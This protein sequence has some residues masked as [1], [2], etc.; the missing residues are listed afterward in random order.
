MFLPVKGKQI[1]TTE[2]KT[3]RNRI[4]FDLRDRLNSAGGR[5]GCTTIDEGCVSV[6]PP[7]CVTTTRGITDDDGEDDDE[8]VTDELVAVLGS[9]R[10]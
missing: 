5:G 2:A 8:D 9:K 3:W 1:Q 4:S 10:I 6:S 7:G